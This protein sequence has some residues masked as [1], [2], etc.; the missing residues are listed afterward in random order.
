[1]GCL[2]G[3]CALSHTR[4]LLNIESKEFIFFCIYSD[5]ELFYTHNLYIKYDTLVRVMADKFFVQFVVY[6]N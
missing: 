5:L 2:C 6:F 4:R 3:T 1:M